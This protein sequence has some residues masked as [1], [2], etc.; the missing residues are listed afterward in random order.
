MNFK[1]RAYDLFSLAVVVV[2]GSFLS[3]LVDQGQTVIAG[4]QISPGAVYV[5]LNTNQPNTIVDKNEQWLARF[6]VNSE[7]TKPVTITGATFYLIGS[8]QR[9]VIS[10]PQLHA[11]TLTSPELFDFEANGELW[12]FEDGYIKQTIEF[13]EPFVVDIYNPTSLDIYMDLTGEEYETVGVMLAELE[14]EDNIGGLPIGG[15]L[16]PVTEGGLIQ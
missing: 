2:V 5:S 6:D 16:L 14:T 12:V 1:F 9:Q 11:L 4:D 7:I 15:K 13:E 3:T 8:L 10:F